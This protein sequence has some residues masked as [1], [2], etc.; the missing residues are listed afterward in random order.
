MSEDTQ[1]VEQIVETPP[2]EVTPVETTPQEELALAQG[3]KRKEDWVKDG[4]D[5]E[6]WRSAKDFIERGELLTTIR[7]LNKRVSVQDQALKAFAQHHE[8]VFEQA[9]KKALDELKAQKRLA[10]REG[11]HE[12]AEQIEEEIDKEKENFRK[13]STNLKK[14]ASATNAEVS[15]D[16]EAWKARNQW[17]TTDEE[18]QADA[19]GFA[20]SFVQRQQQKTGVQPT[21]QEVYAHIEKKIKQAYP[22]KFAP[23]KE[24]PNP[25]S[26]NNGNRA[27][28]ASGDT[29]EMTEMEKKVMKDLVRGGVMT[30]EQ[31]IAELKKVR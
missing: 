18:M 17:Y 16:F 12:L 5:P 29:F 7:S 2:V 6:E 8:T 4:R 19:N 1:M 21:P 9:H 3:W 26:G 14:A 30:K 23:R 13:Q 22:D 27:A 11:E 31:Y 15:P 25:T 28:R 24:A 20:I 10:I